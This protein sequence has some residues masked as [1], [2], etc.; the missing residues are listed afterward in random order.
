MGLTTWARS[1]SLGFYSVL[2]GC[3]AD[4][5]FQTVGC[6][7]DLERLGCFQKFDPGQADLLIVNGGITE[8]A[9]PYL[10]RVYDSLLQ[11]KYVM[12]LGACACSGGVFGAQGV[13]RL[14]PV[15][16]FV[17]GCPPR[18]EAIMNG[19][20]MLQGKIRGNPG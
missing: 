7:Y 11:P 14:F 9:A 19:L 2:G 13:G 5:L 3:C 1:H 18:P 8:K 17:A 20:I 4:E 12:A 6:R 15:D 16:L 10:K